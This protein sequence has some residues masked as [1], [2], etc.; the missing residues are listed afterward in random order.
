MCIPFHRAISCFR[1][2]VL[3]RASTDRFAEEAAICYGPPAARQECGVV[4]GRRDGGGDGHRRQDTTR[5]AP[6]EA[7]GGPRAGMGLVSCGGPG[8]GKPFPDCATEIKIGRRFFDE[9]SVEPEVQ[10]N[11]SPFFEKS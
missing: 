5:T 6:G 7:G 1:P 10:P 9:T 11:K 8:K 4:C 2:R 3:V